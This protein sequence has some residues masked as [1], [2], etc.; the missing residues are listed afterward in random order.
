M[1]EF[2]ELNDGDSLLQTG[3]RALLSRRVGRRR[4]KGFF[5]SVGK[6]ISSVGKGIG[7]F[8][9]SVAKTVGKAAAGIAGAMGS[10]MGNNGAAQK[11]GERFHFLKLALQH[12]MSTCVFRLCTLK[13]PLRCIPVYHSPSH[14]TACIGCQFV[15]AKVHDM[16]DQSAGPEVC[17][18]DLCASLSTKVDGLAILLLDVYE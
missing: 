14:C 10:A 4:R 6:T 9:G 12:S 15:W 16:L 11:E 8:A 17:V 2:Q 18:N 7:K 13:L 1:T 3:H 5:K